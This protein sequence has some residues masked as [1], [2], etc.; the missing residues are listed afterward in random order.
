MFGEC[1]CCVEELP[2]EKYQWFH[3][4]EY[5]P[6]VPKCMRCQA[7]VNILTLHYDHFHR[8]RKH[9]KSQF[10]RQLVPT[11]LAVTQCDQDDDCR[12]SILIGSFI[13]THRRHLA[14]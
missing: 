2:I 13:S 9:Y 8:A 6:H 7:P 10:F 3:L 14:R 11:D 12:P 1:C 5:I 4:V